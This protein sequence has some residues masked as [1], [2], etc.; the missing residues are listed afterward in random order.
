MEFWR[1]LLAALVTVALCATLS[2]LAQA[3]P[4]SPPSVGTTS[5]HGGQSVETQPSSV[6]SET[7]QENTKIPAREVRSAEEEEEMS[8]SVSAGDATEN[9]TSLDSG[10]AGCAAENSTQSNFAQCMEQCYLSHPPQEK[11]NEFREKNFEEEDNQNKQVSFALSEWLE[12]YHRWSYCKDWEPGNE[13]E[14]E[15]GEEPQQNELDRVNDMKKTIKDVLD[16]NVTYDAM[17]YPRYLVRTASGLRVTHLKY[18]E[19]TREW[20]EKHRH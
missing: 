11:I 1:Y 7:L 3:L 8:G 19:S 15:P 18:N 12:D 16:Y 14:V 5:R 10:S 4:V 9:S 20:D 13:C 17:Y 6:R 2:P